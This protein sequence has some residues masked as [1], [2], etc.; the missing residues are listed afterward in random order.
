LGS[1]PSNTVANPKG[2]LKTITT[3]SGHVLDGPTVVTPPLFINPEDD[4]CVEE[5]LTDSDLA[6]YTF[7]VPPPP[8]KKYKPQEKD[9][10]QIHKFWQMFKQ[11]H[12]NITLADALFLLPKY[13]KMLKALLSN[14]EKLQEL[15]NTPIKENCSTI[16][17][18]KLLEKLRDPGKFL[19]PYGFSELKCKT[20]A[21]LGANINLMPLSVCKKLVA[22]ILSTKEPEYSTSMGYEHPNVTPKTK[23]DEIINS[24]VEEL[25]PILS[26]NMVTSEDKKECDVPVCENSPICDDHFDI[27]YDSNND[28]ILSNDDD[29]EDIEYVELSLS[30]LEIVSVEEE[31]KLLSINRL[32]ANIKSLNDNPT[33]DCVL[34][35]SVLIPTSEESNNSLSDN[36]SPEFETFAIIRK[37][38]EVNNI[39]D[40]SLNE[41]LL[42][43]ADLFLASDNSIPS[44]IKNFSNDSEGDIRFLNALLIDDSIPFPNNES[45][46]SDFDNLSF[47]RPPPEPPDAEFDF[48]LDSREEILVVMNDKLEC[49]DPRD[50]IES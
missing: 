40:D 50:E 47:P 36:F 19:I 5:T 11:L 26:K 34:Y 46:E 28:D 3:Q 35:S 1:L 10:V 2:K 30:D 41:L 24:S 42:E 33:L 20:L 17:L 21:D 13:Q 45:S 15:A 14:K 39:S 49:L 27:L 9:E 37:R 12:I 4:E 38:R 44:G 25:I 32:I 29:F 7:K 23:T 22:P 18:K 48:K 43:E 8:V 16:I 6:E 31:N